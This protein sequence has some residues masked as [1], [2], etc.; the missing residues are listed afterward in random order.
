MEIFKIET[1]NFKA[2]GGAMFGVV[3]KLLWQKKYNVDEN[4]LCNIANRCLLVDT[5]DRKVLIDAGIGHKQDEKWLSFHHLHGNDSLEKSLKKHGYHWDDITDLVLTHLHW[6]HCGGAVTQEDSG[7]YELQFPN[8]KIWVSLD[9]WDWATNPNLREEPAYPQE[10]ILPMLDK[11]QI[12]F[13]T[14]DYEIIPGINV[15]LFNGH[16]KGLMLPLIDMGDKKV[17]FA[18]DLIPVVANLPLVYVAA[19]DIY[20]LDSIS[21]KEQILKE[22]AQENWF[23]IFQHDVENEACTVRTTEKGIRAKNIMKIKDIA[24]E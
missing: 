1:G 7:T 9:Q 22:A 6:D 23:I 2:D 19:Y 3:P 8:A 16:T 13:V 15:R 4:N 10:N 5:G 12:E 24:S 17:F 21:E 20:P 18:G 11:G 14:E